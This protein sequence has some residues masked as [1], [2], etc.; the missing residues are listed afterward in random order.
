MHF[1]LMVHDNNLRLEQNLTDTIIYFLY[2][3]QS[4]KENTFIL[5]FSRDN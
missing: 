1:D 3:L 4:G 2:V 5:F